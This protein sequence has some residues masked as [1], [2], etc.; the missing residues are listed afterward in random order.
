[1]IRHSIAVIC[2]LGV[3]ACSANAQQDSQEQQQSAAF[4]DDCT[5][6][7]DTLDTNV[8]LTKKGNCPAPPSFFTSQNQEYTGQQIAE[9]YA[10]F[11][12]LRTL[13]E[14]DRE[15][16]IRRNLSIDEDDPNELEAM[17]QGFRTTGNATDDQRLA[18]FA[19]SVG[20]LAGVTACVLAPGVGCLG[21]VAAGIGW[22]LACKPL[23]SDPPRTDPSKSDECSICQS[24]GS[25]SQCQSKNICPR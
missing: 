20:L 9:G 17:R 6:P 8:K 24:Y 14:E 11:E 23:W 1:M 21:G 10:L 4:T 25:K 16:Y 7:T 2:V 15:P 13:P 12:A 18:C 5:P 22:F 19:S 3:A